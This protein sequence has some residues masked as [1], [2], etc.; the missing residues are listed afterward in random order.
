MKQT[1]ESGR[2]TESICETRTNS[3]DIVFVAQER[4]LTCGGTLG[5]GQLISKQRGCGDLN[6]HLHATTLH[7]A[8]DAT[9]TR[10]QKREM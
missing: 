2:M 8:R 7:T 6:D 1:M 3:V 5:H 4:G 10:I 9:E